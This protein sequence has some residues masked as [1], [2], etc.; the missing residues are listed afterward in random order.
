MEQVLIHNIT[1]QDLVEGCI[2]DK[3]Q[4][5]EA[6]YKKYADKMFT[7]SLTYTDDEDEACDILQ[8]G[9]IKVFR[10]LHKFNFDG[11]FEGWVRKI[12]VNTAL[13][14]YRKR[15][16]Q[17]ENLSV[18]ETHIEPQIEGILDTINANEL[19][20]LVNEL[21]SKAAM[22][23]KLYAIEGYGHKEIAEQ[24]GV[25]VGTSKSQLNRARF[26]LKE[27]ISKTHG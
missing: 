25:T 18:Y 11:S 14:H 10:N 6:L 17:E 1:E 23:L 15:V 5:Q 19:I 24:L 16:R 26:L 7:V 22:V 21:P 27:S 3:R 13:E 9:F 2:A 4:Y 20:K 8:E 12:I